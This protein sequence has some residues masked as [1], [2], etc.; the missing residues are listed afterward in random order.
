MSYTQKANVHT[1]A[2]LTLHVAFTQETSL[3]YSTFKWQTTILPSRLY[4]LSLNDI[5]SIENG[6]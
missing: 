4:Q 3:S 2:F 5:F 1:D 6:Y